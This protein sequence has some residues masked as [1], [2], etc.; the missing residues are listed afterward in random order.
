MQFAKRE[1]ESKGDIEKR[2]SMN[3]VQYV[4][5][6]KSTS[7]ADR[8]KAKYHGVSKR[9]NGKY[10]SRITGIAVCSFVLS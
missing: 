8:G 2:E 4:A 7:N 6:L 9:T 10:Q 1:Y 3:N 5:Y